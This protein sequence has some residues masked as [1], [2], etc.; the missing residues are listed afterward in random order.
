MRLLLDEMIGPRVAVAL[1]E[2]GHDVE[3]VVERIDLRGLPDEAVL[4]HAA[5]TERVLVT[6]NVADFARLHQRWQADGRRHHGVLFV[7]E[8]AFPQG[9]NLI[10]AV[11]SALLAA[12]AGGAIPIAGVALYLQPPAAS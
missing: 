5:E 3:S 6:H 4:E 7:T 2:H 11:V 10:G 12:E 1:R 9:R 8:R